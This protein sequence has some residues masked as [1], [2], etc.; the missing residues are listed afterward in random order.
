MEFPFL[1]EHL[2]AVMPRLFQVDGK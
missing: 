1:E 2:S